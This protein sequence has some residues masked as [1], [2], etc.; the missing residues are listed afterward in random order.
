MKGRPV[1]IDG[2]REKGFVVYVPLA[3]GDDEAVL[4]LEDYNELVA[5]KVYPNWQL[6]GGQAGARGPGGIN[7]LIARVL[8]DAKPGQRVT[9][10]DGDKL[11][12]RRS[13]LECSESGFSVNHDRAML[14]EALSEFEEQKQQARDLGSYHP[15]YQKP[16]HFRS[17]VRRPSSRKERLLAKKGRYNPVS[18]LGA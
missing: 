12:L 14:L 2:D 8:T 10:R 15:R 7:V 1:R 9:Y 3:R 16:G 11:N 6:R 18:A 17:E 13:N 4:D 5:L